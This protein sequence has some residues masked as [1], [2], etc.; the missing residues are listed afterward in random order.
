MNNLRLLSA[1]KISKIPE[2]IQRNNFLNQLKLSKNIPI[3][4]NE[5]SNNN[6]M[7]NKIL[8]KE[9]YTILLT[10][11]LTTFNLQCEARI[12]SFLGKGYYTIGPCGEEL[13][14]S[15]GLLFGKNDKFALHYRHLATQIVYQLNQG[16]DI[17]NIIINRVRAFTCSSKDPVTRGV[18]CSIGDNNNNF[19]VT[20]TLAS[21]CTPAVGRALGNILFNKITSDNKDR[22]INYV[23]LGDGSINNSHFLS[24][25]NISEYI[26]H[27]NYKC[28][29]IFGISDNNI[30][31][32][33]KG[34][35]WLD[36]FKETFL[37]PVI[38]VDGNNIEDLIHKG[39]YCFDYCRNQQKPITI[40]YKN[41]KRRFGHAASDRQEAYLSDEEIND[42]QN[43]NPILNLC[44]YGVK[45]N[46]ISYNEILGLF[47]EIITITEESF[48]NI[49]SESKPNIKSVNIVSKPLIPYPKKNKNNINEPIGKK[50]VMRKNMNKVYDEILK[51]NNNI[52]YIGED[53][54]HGGYYLVTDKLKSKYPNQIL[55]FPPDETSL[56]GIGLG[57]SQSGL[58]PIVEIPYAKYLDCGFDMFN[59][60]A[61]NSWLNNNNNN[62]NGLLIRLQ[63]FDK[64]IFGGNFH[65]HNTIHIPPGI[66]VVCYS[67][68][69]DYVRGMRYCIEQVKAGRIVMT[70][71]STNLLNMRHILNKD[72]K[73]LKLFP[74]SDEFL[75]FD[76]VIKY[77]DGKDLAIISYGNA[78]IES[79]KIQGEIK[80]DSTIIDVPYL[81]DFPKN[82][83]ISGY[84]QILF[85]DN[86]KIGSNPLNKHIIYLKSKKKLPDKWHILTAPFTYNPLGQDITFIKSND[87]LKCINEYF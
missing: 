61:I 60:I 42:L 8:N 5:L 9:D 7:S 13:L 48:D 21:Q 62:N 34:Y 58:I 38:E 85:I 53:I 79:L 29:I 43:F 26:S 6:Q 23:S 4:H 52:I 2:I 57:F 14:G 17:N 68:G 49:I 69:E 66:D 1:N 55:D 31:I 30:S 36:K 3:K 27:R 64:G 73:M 47:N 86:C 35:N 75:K 50:I 10:G 24:A 19:I 77:G 56:L 76:D 78:L 84:K 37:M 82:L 51:N 12:A 54:E 41:L 11:A 67:N 44:E 65:T 46:Y 16:E 32:S 59:E 74:S 20:S 28:P 87:I 72:E 22:I 63:G 25:K 80:Y 33:L 39:N 70:V 83:D 15:I 18:H 40:I 45:Q 71:D 81:S